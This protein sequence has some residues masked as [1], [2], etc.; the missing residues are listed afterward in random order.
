MSD[1]PDAQRPRSWR[2]RVRPRG[3][4]HHRKGQGAAQG[5]S[6]VRQVAVPR[7]DPRGARL[8][9]PRRRRTTSAARANW[10]S[11][12]EEFG[13]GYDQ[14]RSRRSAGFGDDKVAELGER[15]LLG[16]YVR[17]STAAEASRRPATAASRKSSRRSTPRLSVVMGVHQSIGMKT[18]SCSAA[19][20]KVAIPA[21]LCSG[22]IVSPA[23]R[24]RSRTPLRRPPPRVARGA[25]ARR[26]VEAERRISAT[27]ATARRRRARHV[28]RAPRWTARTATS[29]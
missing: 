16:L 18:S 12:R 15:G 29:R 27:S 14:R 21:D 5:V 1:R 13:E 2:S 10:C 24:S 8:P 11:R 9:F 6:L 22:R 7:G 23:S 3:G 19:T 28:S 20:S 17:R 26:L 4:R 25:P